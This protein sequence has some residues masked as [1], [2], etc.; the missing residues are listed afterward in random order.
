MKYE[1]EINITE[2]IIIV[3][4]WFGNTY[5]KVKTILDQFTLLIVYNPSI[6]YTSY[7]ASIIF[8]WYLQI[9]NIY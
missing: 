5:S 2:I 7:F 1:K 6:F 4:G 9:L 3:N 8:I